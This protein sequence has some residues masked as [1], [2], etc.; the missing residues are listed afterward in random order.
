VLSQHGTGARDFTACKRRQQRNNIPEKNIKTNNDRPM[1]FGK[2]L[3]I[4]DFEKKYK[5]TYIHASVLKG[6]GGNMILYFGFFSFI[7]FSLFIL[8]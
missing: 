1:I 3:Q 7:Y 4:Y 6:G 2:P 5:W 8:K